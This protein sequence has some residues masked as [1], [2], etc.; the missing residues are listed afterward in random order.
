[1]AI[2]SAPVVFEALVLVG[3]PADEAPGAVIDAQLSCACFAPAE[4][5]A[6]G[7][8]G[9]Y[10]AGLL[11]I[12]LF[13]GQA[14]FTDTASALRRAWPLKLVP[15][16]VVVIL[17]CVLANLLYFIVWLVADDV[18]AGDFDF[19][20]LLVTL[21]IIALSAASILGLFVLNQR[22]YP[23]RVNHSITLP[24]P[25]LSALTERHRLFTET[26]RA[27]EDYGEQ[28]TSTTQQVGAEMAGEAAKT[29]VSALLPA[30]LG[31]LAGA[32]ASD[33]ATGTSVEEALA[34]LRREEKLAQ[35]TLLF[36]HHLGLTGQRPA[37]V[38]AQ[39]FPGIE[40]WSAEQ[41]RQSQ[42]PQA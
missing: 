31:E 13:L 29:V 24:P 1:M 17:L 23:D 5:D 41:V 34:A 27:I 22:F 12:N 37:A 20:L 40:R 36:A 25:L 4:G 14:G 21:L 11:V 8:A 19:D 30:G 18:S 7:D 42:T 26:K 28:P 16:F 6:D 38:P 33:A 3:T 32:A 2:E 39:D 35:R 10:D 9:S 15:A